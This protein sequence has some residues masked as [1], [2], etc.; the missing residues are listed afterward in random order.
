VLEVPLFCR[1]PYPITLSFTVIWN[2]KNF[3]VN[4]S[5][6][7]TVYKVISCKLSKCESA[8]NLFQ[9]LC[10]IVLVLLIFSALP[11]IECLIIKTGFSFVGEIGSHQKVSSGWFLFLVM[12][13]D[14]LLGTEK[15][16]FVFF[17]QLNAF[18]LFAEFV[19]TF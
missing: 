9:I 15:I 12:A 7:V 5:I 4:R 13:A 14:A 18:C 11:Q 8:R 19:V 3:W 16:N 2:C 10:C 1:R 17:V 6:A